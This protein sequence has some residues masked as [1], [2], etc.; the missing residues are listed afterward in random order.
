MTRPNPTPAGSRPAKRAAANRSTPDKR[1][2]NGLKV[3]AVVLVCLAAL[4]A[5]VVT[6]VGR[7][8]STAVPAPTGTERAD[9]VA[10]LTR[11]AE[12]QGICYGWRLRDDYLDAISVGSNLGDGIPVDANPTRCPRWL[13]VEAQVIYTPASSERN[14]WA[15][16]R[17][18]ASEGV[19]SA[20]YVAGLDRLGVDADAFLDEPGWAICR[21]A[22]FLPLLAAEAGLVPPAPAATST[23]GPAGTPG[24]GLAEPSP[25]PAAGSDFWRDRWSYL[26][27]GAALLVVTLLLLAIGW[28]ERRHQRRAPGTGRR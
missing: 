13:L 17:V 28:F 15:S 16:V 18:T 23:T 8:D 6:T 14:D 11:A 21:A 9:T 2:A 1:T 26:A 27:G 22:V 24:P 7:D 10:V 5:C 4:V 19:S 20:G 12:S 3:A 25:L